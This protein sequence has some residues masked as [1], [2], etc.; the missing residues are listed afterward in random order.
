MRRARL[1]KK[2]P[3]EAV[4]KVAA[5]GIVTHKVCHMHGVVPV[6]DC[7]VGVYPNGNPR[8]C[9]ARAGAQFR[10]WKDSQKV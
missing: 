5:D 2:Q 1:G 6:T 7:N 4:Q 3:P 10:A 8:I 9:K